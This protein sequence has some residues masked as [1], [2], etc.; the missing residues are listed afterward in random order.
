MKLCGNVGRIE[1]GRAPKMTQIGGEDSGK[2]KT[3]LEKRWIEIE[4]RSGS[5][6][7]NECELLKD[8]RRR[9]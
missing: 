7:E 5:F 4:P 3:N 1:E 2:G 8:E 9:L 6:R